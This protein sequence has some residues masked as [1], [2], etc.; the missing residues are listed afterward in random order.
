MGNNLNLFTE[1]YEGLK[2]QIL[3]NKLRKMKIMNRN[4]FSILLTIK[5]VVIK[6][7]MSITF[8]KNKEY[9]ST[10]LSKQNTY[11]F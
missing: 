8:F 3:K 6:V 11:I 7:Y 9:P 4:Y 2:K 10:I 1:I 5:I